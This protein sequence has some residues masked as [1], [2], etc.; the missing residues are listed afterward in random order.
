M[1]NYGLTARIITKAVLLSGIL[2]GGW[3]PALVLAQYI[4]IEGTVVLE[5]SPPAYGGT[6]MGGYATTPASASSAPNDSTSD[7]I[8]IWLVGQDSRTTYPARSTGQKVLDQVNKRFKPRLMAVMAGE[9]VRIKNSDP[10]YH[11][12]FSLSKTRRFDVG[13]RSPEEHQVVQ[14]NKAGRVDVFCDIHSNMHAVIQVLPRQTV[15]WKILEK[16][17]RFIFRDISEGRYTLHLFS[18]GNRA[19][20]VQVRAMDA[21]KITLETIRLGAP[22]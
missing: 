17:G 14:F 1:R 3:A 10:V 9:T 11:N 4:D 5:H 19:G 21:R 20:Q 7:D 18:L 12:V 22:R 2:A 13:R 6:T 15:A 16:S 8:L